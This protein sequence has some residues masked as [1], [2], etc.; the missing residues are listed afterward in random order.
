MSNQEVFL[1]VDEKKAA[2]ILD[3]AVQTLRNWRQ[4][5]RGPAYFKMGRSVRYK[6]DDLRA[7]TNKRRI[8][9]ERGI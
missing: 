4:S 6:V 7:Y 3:I 8:D 5:R 2:K 9:P 1:F